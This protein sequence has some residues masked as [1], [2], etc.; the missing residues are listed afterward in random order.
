MCWLVGWLWRWCCSHKVD[1]T[2]TTWNTSYFTNGTLEVKN[3]GL[4]CYPGGELKDLLVFIRTWGSPIWII[5]LQIGWNH[6]HVTLALFSGLFHCNLLGFSLVVLGWFLTLW[7]W[8]FRSVK[9]LEFARCM[10]SY[11][12]RLWFGWTTGYSATTFFPSTI[13]VR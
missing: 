9:I 3:K 6:Q 10:H 7:Q 8:F 2:L 11:M 1:A 13:M 4:L 5:L 12:H